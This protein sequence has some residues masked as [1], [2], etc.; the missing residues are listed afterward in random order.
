[1]ETKYVSNKFLTFDCD[2]DIGHGKL[3]FFHNTPSN[4]VLSFYE[5]LLNSLFCFL[6][7]G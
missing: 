3:H 1:M 4:F 6:S 7:Y 5:V 2:L